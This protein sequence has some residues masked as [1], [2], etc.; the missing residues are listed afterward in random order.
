MAKRRGWPA[1]TLSGIRPGVATRY[2]LKASETFDAGDLV[3][4]D[5]NEDVLEV[6]GADPT[7]I[8]GLAAEAAANVVEA[9]YVMVW[10][11][12]GDLVFA[13]E[14][15]N[16]PTADD[17]NQSYGVIQDGDGIYTVDGTETSNTRVY[18]N[19]VDTTR[20]L[21]FVT[22]LDATRIVKA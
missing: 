15:D 11:A 9:G 2:T 16:N 12:T 20:N 21:Y 1:Y 6:S 5:A 18:V 13:M 10:V 19:S 8:L 7:T 17:V 4:I 3:T 22:V 14:G